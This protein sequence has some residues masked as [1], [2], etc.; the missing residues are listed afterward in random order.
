VP[1]IIDLGYV[2]VQG[3]DG[4]ITGIVTTADLSNQFVNGS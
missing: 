4:K 1:R 2:F 3:A